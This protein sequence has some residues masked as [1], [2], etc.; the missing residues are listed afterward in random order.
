MKAFAPFAY[1][2]EMA[3]ILKYLSERGALCVNAAAIEE[4][5]EEFS[6]TRCAQWLCTDDETLAEFAEWLEN[7][8]V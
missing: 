1:P 4:M 3:K 8:E 6:D 5:Y 2:D 7:K